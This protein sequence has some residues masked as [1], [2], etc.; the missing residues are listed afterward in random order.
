M[1]LFG[2]PNPLI[3]LAE[4]GSYPN[5]LEHQSQ[6]FT[7]FKM[8]Y[9]SETNLKSEDT[10]KTGSPFLPDEL[11]KISVLALV[12]SPEYS[13]RDEADILVKVLEDRAHSF[14]GLRFKELIIDIHATFDPL[15]LH[16]Y[17]F[18]IENA[19]LSLN[20][21]PVGREAIQKQLDKLN[22][23]IP[24]YWLVEPYQQAIGIYEVEKEPA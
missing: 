23:E 14:C 9:R 16:A 20:L 3:A 21:I 4:K 19:F 15:F 17:K 5:F 24:W 1:G 8:W 2:K 10:V 22:K 6:M 18:R 12:C 7:M 11:R 13:G